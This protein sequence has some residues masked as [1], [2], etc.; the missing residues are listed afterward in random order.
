MLGDD[1]DLRNVRAL[2][3]NLLGQSW[4]LARYGPG[5]RRLAICAGQASYP[6]GYL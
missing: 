4:P 2:A 5:P 6:R 3:G 1:A